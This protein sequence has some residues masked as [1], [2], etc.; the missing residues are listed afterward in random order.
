MPHSP[1]RGSA[2]PGPLE[3][4]L[5]QKC[6]KVPLVFGAAFY[7]SAVHVECQSLWPSW[8]QSASVPATALCLSVTCVFS[9]VWP[10]AHVVPLSSWLSPLGTV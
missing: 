4:G 3:E 7:V 10:E 5:L 8:S 1:G 2:D 6:S 9:S